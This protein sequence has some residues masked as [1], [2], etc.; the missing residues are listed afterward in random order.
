MST[1]RKSIGW[2]GILGLVLLLANASLPAMA[3]PSYGN[4]RETAHALSNAF[5]SAAEEVMPAV[6]TITSFKV[7]RFSSRED[8]FWRFFGNPN[9]QP[10]EREIPQQGLGSGVIVRDDGIILTNNHVVAEAEELTVLLADGRELK[11]EIVGRDPKTDLAVIRIAADENV[12]NLPVAH[13]GDSDV[14]RVGD[15]VLAAGSPFQLNQ[16]VTAGII[17]AKGRSNLRLASYEDFI[18]TDAAINPGNS[19]GAMINLDGQ[20][21]G[22]NTAIASRNGGYQGIGFAI[23]INMARQVMD[24]ILTHGRVIRGQLGVYIQEITREMSEALELGTLKGALV[25]QVNENGPADKAGIRERDVIIALDGKPVENMQDLRFRIA[26]LPPDTRVAVTILRD[27]EKKTIDVVLGELEDEEAEIIPASLSNDWQ[28]KLG[29]RLE[30]LTS[31][32]RSQL[33]L[34]ESV[35]GIVVESVEP[36]GSAAEAGLR[37]GDVIEKVGDKKIEALVDFKNA[38]DALDG[39]KPFVLRVTR[40]PQKLFLAMVL[41]K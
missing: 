26:G 2:L 16:T 24:S 22:I 8:P 28:D 29:F 39:S 30:A 11:A 4:D 23:P 36:T 38:L 5:A 17:S 10:E 14:M 33:D 34:D 32:I 7:I 13:L 41:P 40:G 20:V 12:S 1:L 25:S 6:V 3:D 21:I 19:G 31:A 27:G 15:W 18:Q 35:K 9:E 37:P